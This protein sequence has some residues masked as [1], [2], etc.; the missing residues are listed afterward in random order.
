MGLAGHKGNLLNDIE[1]L[2]DEALPERWI[3]WVLHRERGHAFAGEL[4][5]DPFGDNGR[6]SVLRSVVATVVALRR[7]DGLCDRE[8]V[9]RYRL[10]T[11]RRNAGAWG[12]T[13]A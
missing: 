1:R 5:S 9:E 4:F 7:L 13:T 10:D 11:S 12:A 6:R 8:A 2:Y 3:Y